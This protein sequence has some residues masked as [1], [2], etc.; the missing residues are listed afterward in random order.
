MTDNETSLT[1]DSLMQRV[2]FLQHKTIIK[3]LNRSQNSSHIKHWNKCKL[4]IHLRNINRNKSDNSFPTC[5]FQ[6]RVLVARV[7]PGS[8]GHKAGLTLD[9]VPF[10]YRASPTHTHSDGTMETRHSPHMH[11]SG[12]WEEAWGPSKTYTDVGRTCKLH[13]DG[14][15]SW[16]KLFSSSMLYGNHVEAPCKDWLYPPPI[17]NHSLWCGRRSPAPT[18][19]GQWGARPGT[20]DPHPRIGSPVGNQACIVPRPLWDL[21]FAKTPSPWIE[22][23]NFTAYL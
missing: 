6:F 8:F 3:L 13:T 9:R 17:W 23:A 20:Q 16:K 19:K 2:T 21:L 14:G 22:A 1:V 5:L 11:T 12:M 10:H 4:S 18:R 7:S 15:T